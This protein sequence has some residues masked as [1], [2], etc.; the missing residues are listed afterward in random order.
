MKKKGHSTKERHGGVG[1]RFRPRGRK[2]KAPPR[3]ECPVCGEL[4][5][6]VTFMTDTGKQRPKW[7]CDN[8]AEVRE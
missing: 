3:N 6:V 5:G 4:I 1:Q 7:F 8:C 2:T